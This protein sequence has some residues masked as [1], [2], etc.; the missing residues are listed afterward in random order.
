MKI[1]TEW[2]EFIPLVKEAPIDKEAASKKPKK[3]V[4][5]GVKNM[6]LK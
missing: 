5:E 6:K 4:S 2:K 1:L 3:D